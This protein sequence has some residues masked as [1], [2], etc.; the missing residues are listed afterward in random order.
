LRNTDL[1]TQPQSYFHWNHAYLQLSW[2]F[3]FVPC[4]EGTVFVIGIVKQCA[5]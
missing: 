4:G 3:C 2:N 5:M 1:F